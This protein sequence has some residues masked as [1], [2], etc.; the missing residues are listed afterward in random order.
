MGND[1]V[2]RYIRDAHRAYQACMSSLGVPGSR[3]DLFALLRAA[4]RREIDRRGEITTPEG[5]SY[6]YHIH[7]SGYSFEDSNCKKV[8]RFDVT[9]VNGSSALRFTAWEVYKYASSIGEP[10]SEATVASELRRISGEESSMGHVLEGQ[11]DYYYWPD[12]AVP[13]NQGQ[14]E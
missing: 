14:M 1:L 2:H 6:G 3:S 7:G 13:C 12:E 9:T 8:I 11:T 4:R 5:E 10:I